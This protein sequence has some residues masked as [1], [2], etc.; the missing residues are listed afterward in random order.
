MADPDLSEVAHRALSDWALTPISVEAVSHSE[1][2]VFRVAADDGRI[3]VLRMHRPGYHSYD[4]LI[5]EQEW[6]AALTAAGLDVPQPRRLQDGRPYG[7][8][9]VLGEE[10]WVGVLEWV[11]GSTMGSLLETADDPAG[12]QVRF[13][14]LG[15]L[16][17]AL[18]NQAAGW[19]PPSTFTRH[20]LDEHGLMG[21]APFWGPFWEIGRASC[22]ERVCQYV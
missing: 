12:A 20:C 17:G 4:E 1:N 3:Y 13:A 10:R 2:I 21:I 6:T 11:E 8:V 15:K 7:R 22:R 5:S 14:Q 19:Q 18:H 16:L 9:Q